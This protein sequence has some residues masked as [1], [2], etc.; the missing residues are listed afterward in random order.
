MRQ[1]DVVVGSQVLYF[2]LEE[3]DHKNLHGCTGTVYM[4]H[5]WITPFWSD[6]NGELR[7]SSEIVR[8]YNAPRGM[9]YWSV[10]ADKVAPIIERLVG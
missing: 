1:Q 7:S 3:T 9:K 8:R 6:Y 5:G 10:D 2:S 4:E